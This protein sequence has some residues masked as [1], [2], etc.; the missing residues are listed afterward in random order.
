MC[1]R[2]MM[3]QITAHEEQVAEYND[4][5]AAMEEELK[6]VWETFTLKLLL[7]SSSCYYTES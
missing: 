1:F 3:G 2:G 5:I 7:R 4:R 6:K